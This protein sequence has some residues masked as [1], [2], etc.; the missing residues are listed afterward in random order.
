MNSASASL[1]QAAY[2]RREEL[3]NVISHGFGA[4]LSIAATIILVMRARALGDGLT[5]LGFSL[6]GAGLVLLFSASTVYHASVLPSA[7]RR[8]RVLDHSSIYVLIAGTY[9]AFC[10]TALRGPLGWAIFAVIWALAISGIVLALFFTGRFKALGVA[11]YVGM[12]WIIVLAIGPLRRS[13]GS[14]A[15]TF[16][17]AG[18]IAYTVGACIYAL[19][20]LRWNHPIWHVF[21]LAGAACHFVSALAVLG[22]L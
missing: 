9:S 15:L 21:V 2:P 14:E 8:L 16:L 3:A 5:V 6:F 1:H 10:L 11:A 7:R 22:P 18:G 17:F 20:K 19:K 13:M 4:L 12:G